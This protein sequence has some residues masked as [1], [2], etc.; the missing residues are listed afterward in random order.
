MC[1]S[2]L[3]SHTNYKEFNDKSLL[4]LFITG[5]KEALSELFLRHKSKMK[6]VAFRITK[7]D[8][9]AEDVVQNSMIS[10]MKNAHK[11]RGESAVTTWIYKI[12][13]TL[14]LIN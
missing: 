13:Q 4:D 5:E 10:I 6:S 1:V 12:V 9:D 14:Q 11:F 3:L 2:T 8:Q 7:N